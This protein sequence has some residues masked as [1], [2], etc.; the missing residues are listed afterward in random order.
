MLNFVFDPKL[1]KES[2]GMGWNHC[3]F[4][5]VKEGEK[6]PKDKFVVFKVKTEKGARKAIESKKVNVMFGF[7]HIHAIDSVHYPRSGF[8]QIIAKLCA[9]YNVKVGIS[10][11]D[12]L[13]SSLWRRAQLDRRIKL[14]SKL[15]RKY[16]VELLPA[17]FGNKIRSYD[18]T[19]TIFE[20]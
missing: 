20:C 19:R 4:V 17:S 10:V 3:D 12:Y 5:L 1:V 8:D 2:E 18:D 6:I 7:E 9:E 14:I 16:N 11:S 15:C 13:E